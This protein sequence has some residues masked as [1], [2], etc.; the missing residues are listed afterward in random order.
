MIDEFNNVKAFAGRLRSKTALYE[1]SSGGAFT[2]L[3]NFF[4]QKEGVIACAS[5][6][7]LDN[8]EVFQVIENA[9]QRDKARG[10][11]YVQSII[12]DIYNECRQWIVQNPAKMLMFVGTGCQAAGFASYLSM[13]GLR[14]RAVIV[15]IICHGVSSPAIWKDYTKVIEN[16]NGGKITRISF[17]DKR[18]GW[19][20]PYAYALINNQEIS[21]GDY[22]K[23]YYNRCILRPSCH[24]CPYATVER[25][26]DITIGDFWHISDNYPELYSELGTSLLLVHSKKGLEIIRAIETDMR[27]QE[28]EVEKSLQENLIRPTLIS[29]KRKVF[30]ED[31]S[32][33]GIRFVLEKSNGTSLYWRLVKKLDI[34]RGRLS[35]N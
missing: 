23:M 1:S 27:I 8:T 29:N 28:T 5:Y 2:A 11:I 18:N 22:C 35:E 14:D 17:K 4:L 20:H 3:S 33:K 19:S 9:E 12:G 13:Q 32:H 31:Y 6:D 24:K 10:S 7:Y 15:D 16:F 26:T 21:I 25:T 30:W 34:L